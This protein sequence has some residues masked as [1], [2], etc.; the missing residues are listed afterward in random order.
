VAAPYF[1]E[2]VEELFGAVV[3]HPESIGVGEAVEAVAKRYGAVVQPFLE[4]AALSG[5]LLGTTA[6][7]SS[8]N[9]PF[10]SPLRC[11]ILDR[12]FSSV[13][14]TLVGGIFPRGAFGGR[15]ARGRERVARARGVRGGEWPE[16]ARGA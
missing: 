13:L 4:G 6:I 10:T 3:V 15:G 11:S 2:K 9:L 12:Q 7:L 5:Q 8:A 1:S 14:R 16:L